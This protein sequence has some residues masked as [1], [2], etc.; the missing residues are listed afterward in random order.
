MSKCSI[1]NIVGTFGR[2]I[3]GL[4]QKHSTYLHISMPK[5]P[6]AL[7]MLWASPVY[8]R[9]LIGM[10]L[11]MLVCE[12]DAFVYSAFFGLAIFS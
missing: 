4:S 7:C 6:S 9:Q 5:H 8:L 10:R 1:Q 12:R 3:R 11:K 2:L